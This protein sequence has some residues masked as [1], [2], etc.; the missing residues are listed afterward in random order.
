[1]ER[2]DEVTAMTPPGDPGDAGLRL[3]RKMTEGVDYDDTSEVDVL[4]TVG[5][6]AAVA[7]VLGGV[8]SSILLGCRATA[9]TTASARAQ[10]RCPSASTTSMPSKRSS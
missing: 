1:M 2:T 6:V 10:S 7:L 5:T 9:G 4:E 3:W 8:A